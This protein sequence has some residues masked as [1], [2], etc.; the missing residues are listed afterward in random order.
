[1]IVFSEVGREQIAKVMAMVGKSHASSR[2]VDES[3]GVGAGKIVGENLDF[4]HFASAG[5]SRITGLY[6]QY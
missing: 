4:T 2:Q 6:D 5:V 3:N 1:M